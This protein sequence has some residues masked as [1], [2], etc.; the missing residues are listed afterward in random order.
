MATDNSIEQ[1]FTANL[2]R[3][4]ALVNAHDGL[5]DQSGE[6]SAVAVD[7]LRAA[8]VLLHASL[9]DILRSL[10]ELRLPACAP[11]VF[12]DFTFV[13]PS[14]PRRR[15]AKITLTELLE[16]RGRTVDEVLG[17]TIR[18]YLETTNYN[19]VTEVVTALRRIGLRSS[20]VEK[21]AAELEALMRRRHWIAH[22]A[23]RDLRSPPGAFQAQPL[24]AKLVV[25]W[26]DAV[27]AVGYDVAGQ[28]LAA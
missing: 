15:P 11:E 4:V 28:P 23:D 13:L 14:D 2:D 10:E 21:N 3:A 27:A 8:V 12:R 7:F 20:V 17:A 19:N 1:R 18:E 6:A 25:R 26:R 24:D 16:Y 5:V 22:R 9:E